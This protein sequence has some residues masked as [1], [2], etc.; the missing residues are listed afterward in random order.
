MQ[1]DPPELGAIK[2]F[3]AKAQKMGS[4]HRIMNTNLG[5]DRTVKFNTFI[6]IARENNYRSRG[7][8]FLR[9]Y[10]ISSCLAFSISY[11]PPLSGFNNIYTSDG[12]KRSLAYNMWYI[13][14][15]YNLLIM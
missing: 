13:I 8:Q 3:D 5:T 2:V 1:N 14:Y 15:I 6:Y 9:I 12:L 10:L 11:Y 4:G 7:I